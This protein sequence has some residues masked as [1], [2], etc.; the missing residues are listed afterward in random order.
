MS[1]KRCLI[2]EYVIKP[3]I[4]IV[5]EGPNPLNL[6]VPDIGIITLE[7]SPNIEANNIPAKQ[8]LIWSL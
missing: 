8:Y 7:M 1:I 6:E 3:T 4:I 5:L 2:I